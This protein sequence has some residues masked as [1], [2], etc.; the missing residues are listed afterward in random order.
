MTRQKC[1]LNENLFM[2]IG[3]VP[4]WIA[5]V[6]SVVTLVAQNK[7]SKRSAADQANLASQAARD[8]EDLKNSAKEEL[9]KVNRKL[10][11]E[12]ITQDLDELLAVTLQYW[13]SDGREGATSALMLKVKVKDLSARCL[14]Y[15]SF[16]WDRAGEDFSLI[17]RHITGG[18]FEVLSRA[19]LSP[20]DPFIGTASRLISDFR[21]NVRRA[22]DRLDSLI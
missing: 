6:L 9:A 21:V 17:R 20:N 4:A 18:H 12:K 2:D 7:Q 15:R 16:L 11:L 1:R 3:D 10:R 19:A 14:E 8:R 5:L 13:T 22:T